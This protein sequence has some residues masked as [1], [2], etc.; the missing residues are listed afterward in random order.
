MTGELANRW[1]CRNWQMLMERQRA[2]AAQDGGSSASPSGVSV[3]SGMSRAVLRVSTT[4]RWRRVGRGGPDGGGDA[5]AGVAEQLPDHDEFDGP[6]RPAA[7][8]I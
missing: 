2:R 5:D 4:L 1:G 6:G 7:C 8:M 3:V